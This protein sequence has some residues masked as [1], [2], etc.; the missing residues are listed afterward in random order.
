MERAAA[1][2]ERSAINE[3]E[4]IVT[5]SFASEQ[6]VQRWYGAEI[7]QIDSASVNQDR[8]ETGLGVTLFNHDRGFVLGKIL[9]CSIDESK[10]KAHADVQFDTDEDAEKIW[11]KVLS[12]TLQGVSVGYSVDVW[13]EVAAGKMSSSGRFTGPA[14]IATRWT[15]LEISIVSV[16]ADDSVGVGRQFENERDD[17]RMTLEEKEAMEREKL[18]QQQ[19]PPAAAPPA[20]PVDPDAIRAAATKEAAE[21]TALCRDF[22]VDATEYLQRGD[23]IAVVK[24]AILAKKR[25]ENKPSDTTRIQ[26]AED[27]KVKFSRAAVDAILLRDGTIKVEKPAEGA[28][29]LRSMRLRDLMIECCERAGNSKARY[30]EDQELIREALTGAGAFPGILSNAASKSLSDGYAA[31]ET[32]YQLWAGTG[33]NPDFKAATHYRL[34]EAG[35]LLELKESGEFKADEATEE[36][37]SKSVLT[38]GRSWGLTRKAIINDD[39]SALTRLPARYAASAAR[40]I[41]KLCYTKLATAGNYTAGRGNLVDVGAGAV[42]SVATLGAGRLAMRKQKNLR[43]KETLNIGP[44]FLIHPASLETTVDTL[45]GSITDPASTNANVKNPF[46]GKLTPVCDAELDALDAYAWYLAAQAGLVDTIEVTYLNGVQTPTI[47]NQVSFDI[48][49]MKWRIY[50]DY[51]VTVLDFRGLFKNAGH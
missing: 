15:P 11:Q 33:S 44:K 6:P 23:S 16:P 24:D 2:I 38:F 13:E 5:L 31:A 3:E 41:N 19:P 26:V 10:R 37:A 12:G 9:R 34:S 51:G 8:I 28:N 21:I 25:A 17:E 40:G 48:L 32:T 20:A 30:M 36:G 43:S 35:D 27:E 47:E 4:R 29:E 39:L 42:P 22:G 49:G 45:L 50:I 7:L 46:Y 1:T 14:Y 18:R